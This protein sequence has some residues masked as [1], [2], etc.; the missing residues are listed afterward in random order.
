M[1]SCEGPVLDTSRHDDELAGAKLDR[2]V[3]ELNS[4]TSANS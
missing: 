2:T 1:F 4:E 3:A